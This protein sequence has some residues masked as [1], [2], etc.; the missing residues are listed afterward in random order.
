MRTFS[1][2]ATQWVRT[3][4]DGVPDLLYTGPG[5]CVLAHGATVFKCA[6]ARR[7]ASG[8]LPVSVL[9]ELYAM[10]L[11]AGHPTAV[12]ASHLH[13]LP[14]AG[15]VCWELPR[16]DC[17]L[18]CLTGRPGEGEEA[19][20][21][22]PPPAA[23]TR[24]VAR[25]VAAALQAAHARGLMHRDVKPDNVL[26]HADTGDL[27]LADWGM[28]RLWTN[29]QGTLS[30]RGVF[31][32]DYLPPEVLARSRA[33]TPAADMWSFGALLHELHTGN[34]AG[35]CDRTPRTRRERARCLG[36]LR[37]FAADVSAASPPSFLAGGLL[38]FDPAQRLTATQ[39]LHALDDDGGAAAAEADRRAALTWLT[40]RL[41]V[42]VPPPTPAVV[43][44]CPPPLKPWHGWDLRS[45]AAAA[46]APIPPPPDHLN[47]VLA[48]YN[49]QPLTEPEVRLAARLLLHC[50][51]ATDHPL[52]AVAAHTLAVACIG[53]R[54]RAKVL[55]STPPAGHARHQLATAELALVPHLAS[56]AVG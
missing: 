15:M 38:K 56:A 49:L 36:R 3:L 25:A 14:Q 35:T 13:W 30:H 44:P 5:R 32:L 42:A 51:P 8:F 37:R 11:M 41:P 50:A 47:A 18:Y 20:P 29:A 34:P 27:A 54:A 22:P 52:T 1:Q 33:Y 48:K 6:R 12:A 19:T 16:F 2:S 28:A 40:T 39:V 26:V 9:R 21:P 17:D 24:H 7:T 4:T 46:A 31:T 53:S 10:L 55:R 23:V 43:D 45:A